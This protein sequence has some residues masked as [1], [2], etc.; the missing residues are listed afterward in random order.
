VAGRLWPAG[1]RAGAW[2]TPFCVIHN[3]SDFP[4][5]SQ[6]MDRIMLQKDGKWTVWHTSD[7]RWWTVSFER[8]NRVCNRISWVDLLVLL[9]HVVCLYLSVSKIRETSC[10]YLHERPFYRFCESKVQRLIVQPRRFQ[11]KHEFKA[12]R[13]HLKMVHGGHFIEFD[14]APRWWNRPYVCK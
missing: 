6:Y 14:A 4:W 11:F 9:L 1:C 12:E 3:C 7:S 5:F 10:N 2:R 13:V 8:R